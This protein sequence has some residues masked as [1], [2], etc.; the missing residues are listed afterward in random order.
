MCDMAHYSGLIATGLMNSP[1]EYCDIV[2]S[3]T[4]KSL[5]GPRSGMIFSKVK[6]SND[7][8][9]AVFPMLQGGPHNVAI[10]ALAVQLKEVVTPEFHTY[11]KQVVANS[12]ALAAALMEKGETVV[13][14][15]TCNHMVMWDLR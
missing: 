8:N 13:T 10:A 14:N 12:K 4:H 7:I 11:S 2:T 9:F 15:G 1:F 3:T 6:Y 5:R